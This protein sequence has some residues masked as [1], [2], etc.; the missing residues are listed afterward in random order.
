MR[1]QRLDHVNLRT[2]RLADTVHFYTEVLG[3]RCGDIPDGTPGAFF[4]DAGGVPVLHVMA[5]DRSK[6]QMV[7]KLEERLGRRIPERLE[8][9]GAV[10][11]IALGGDDYDAFRRHFEE[12]SVPYRIV[13]LPD[14]TPVQ[15]VVMDPNGIPVE[16]NFRTPGS[17][18]A[19]PAVVR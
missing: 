6:P 5:I 16:V 12:K 10:D 1:I 9:G 17:P 11:H 15:L 18:S 8:G 2:E 7:A 4:Y 19:P 14:G 13:S 3:L